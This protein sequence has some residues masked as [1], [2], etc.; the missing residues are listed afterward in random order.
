[1][2]WCGRTANPEWVLQPTWATSRRPTMRSA[3]LSQGHWN[4]L[5]EDRQLQKG[6]RA[7]LPPQ[8]AVIS[9]FA[10]HLVPSPCY[11]VCGARCWSSP[12]LANDLHCT[13]CLRRRPKWHAALDLATASSARHLGRLWRVRR[14]VA[15]NPPNDQIV[16]LAHHNCTMPTTTTETNKNESWERKTQRRICHDETMPSMQ[17]ERCPC[18]TSMHRG[19]RPCGEGG[20][21][22]DA[23]SILRGT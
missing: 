6:S 3:P 23:I 8:A 18:G 4:W 16:F 11:L 14:P 17:R 10:V 13:M 2:R 19:G 22:A 12:L 20:V 1:M 21:H 15:T 9:D 7:L 5:H